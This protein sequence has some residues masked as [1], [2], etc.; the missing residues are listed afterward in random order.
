MKTAGLPEFPGGIGSD[1]PPTVLLDSAQRQLDALREAVDLR[2]TA[3]E[4]VL[5]DPSRSGSLESLI[6]DLSRLATEEAQ[7]T[8]ARACVGMRLDA[9]AQI[10][11]SRKGFQTSIEQEQQASLEVRQAL[12]QAQVRIAA[13]TREKQTELEALK[14]RY[15]ATLAKERSAT[16]EL[17]QMAADLEK[18]LAVA[19]RDVASEHA[20]LALLR[21]TLNDSEAA[22]ATLART[23]EQLKADASQSTT[24]AQ[25]LRQS[26]G[27]G[28][29]AH[30]ETQAQ[31][32][33]ARASGTEM[34]ASLEQAKA[35]FNSELQREQEAALVMLQ[36]EKDEAAALLAREREQA[37][38][39]LRQ[40]KDTYQDELQRERQRLAALEQAHQDATAGLSAEQ[41]GTDT[42]RKALD[43]ARR[44]AQAATQEAQDLRGTADTLALELHHARE[45]VSDLQRENAEAATHLETEHEHIEK[46]KA[47]IRRGEERV[48]LI[49]AGEKQAAAAYDLLQQELDQERRRSTGLEKAHKTAAGDLDAVRAQCEDLRQALSRASAAQSQWQSDASGEIAAARAEAE[50]A[51]AEVQAALS[52][53]ERAVAAQGE[54]ARAVNELRASLDV[55]SRERDRLVRDLQAARKPSPAPAPPLVI[56]SLAD[57]VAERRSKPRSK[58]QPV[59]EVVQEEP[60]AAP[61]PAQGAPKAVTE[62]GWVAIAMATRYAFPNK[63]PVQINGHDGSLCDLSLTGC[64]LLAPGVLKPGQAIKL[65]IPADPPIQCAGKVVWAQ[66]EPPAAGRPLAYRAGVQFTKA[67]EVA[68]ERF[69]QSHGK[70]T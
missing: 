11:K 14:E 54:S 43:E 2:L 33:A 55:V 30:A 63:L 19:R 16:S 12:E 44:Q 36:R 67:D 28:E 39:E 4:D 15:E 21:T 9:E 38:S 68:L 20:A 69:T 52:R 66:L 13:L 10:A 48:S 32:A 6:L 56:Q 51:R 1:A 23:V 26:L 50:A 45:R 64:Q 49:G 57:S 18:S 22:N 46:L 65:Q 53:L 24:E 58:K 70:A 40:A 37:A 34:R 25:R 60:A 41:S 59:V 42:L 29:R 7:T 62:D 47:E 61:A 3:L 31:L 27:D 5:S 8:A 17:E 35:T